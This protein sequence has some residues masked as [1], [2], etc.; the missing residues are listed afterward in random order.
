MKCP[1][2]G[3]GLVQVEAGGLTLDACQGG[4]GG[5]WFDRLELATF[6]EPHEAAGEQLLHIARDDSVNVAYDQKRVCPR[7]TDVKMLKHFFSVKRQVTID[8]CPQCGG[9]WLDFGELGQIRDQYATED[10]RRAAAARYFGD[11]FGEKLAVMKAEAQAR[12]ED[13]QKFANI[14]RFVCPSYYIPG[15]QSWGAF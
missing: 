9:V 1:A 11:V 3:R 2:C 15:D 12:V 8:E 5:I 14:F 6:D 4:C 13:A 7:C 10:E